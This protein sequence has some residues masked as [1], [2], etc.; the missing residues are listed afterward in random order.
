L[1]SPIAG[2][3]LTVED[4]RIAAMRPDVT[5]PVTAGY[6]CVESLMSVDLCNGIEERLAACLK[7]GPDGTFVEVG[8]EQ[9]LDEIGAK[10]GKL[11]DEYGPR[12]VALFFGTAAYA[13]S[14][15]I[16]LCRSFMH[17]IGSPNWF[18]TMTIDQSAA[19]VSVLRMGMV[20]SGYR[21]LR[22]LATVMY[23]GNN[24]M[25]SHQGGTPPELR[26]LRGSGAKIIVIDPRQTETAK[27]ADIHL[28][29]V[30]GEDVRLLAALIHVILF[31]NLH[32]RAFCDRFA[33]Q[34]DTLR[35]SVAAFTLRQSRAPAASPRKKSWKPP[36]YSLQPAPGGCSRPQVFAWGRI[37]PCPPPSPARS[38]CYAAISCGPAIQRAMA[39]LLLPS[40]GSPGCSD[41]TAR[42]SRNH[43][44]AATIL[45]LCS[46]SFRPERL[47]MK[48]CMTERTGSGR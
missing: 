16:P 34:V 37:E 20:L 8:A 44:C 27:L 43:V 36:A 39:P 13:Q 47:P 15:A 42:G 45:A 26:E 6:S 40:A 14:L 2:S 35:Q 25:V 28:P 48:S 18:S 23:V 3:S 7:R 10:V 30:P 4:N 32:D 17:E 24:P 46:A 21:P 38:T 29:V 31:E 9:A 11:L 5:H 41:P 33:I 22:D 12:S 19:W 1:P